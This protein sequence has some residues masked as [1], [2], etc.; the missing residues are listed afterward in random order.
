MKTKP[1]PHPRARIGNKH[2][3]KG[4]LPRVAICVRLDP[5]TV[6]RIKQ[7]AAEWGISQADTITIAIARI[8]SPHA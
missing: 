8:K 5:A 6:A 3:Q 1:K 2:A 4:P 7:L